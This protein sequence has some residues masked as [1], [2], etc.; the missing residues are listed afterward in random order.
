MLD[1]EQ[2]KAIVDRDGSDSIKSQA[3]L[4]R[5]YY[6]G[7]HDIMDY[8]I[9]FY[10]AHGELAEDKGRSNLRISHPYFTELC[11]QQV[12]YMLSD[13]EGYISA[14]ENKELQER[15][16]DYFDEDFMGSM[17]D[18]LTD[19]VSLGFGYLYCYK[20]VEDRLVFE[21]AD[22]MGVVEVPEKESPDGEAHIIYSYFDRND[23]KGA[24]IVKIQVWDDR[25]TYYWVRNANGEIVYDEEVEFNP[26]PHVMYKSPDGNAFG[27]ALG[28]IP[29]F[30]LDNNRKRQSNLA[31]IKNLIDDY[32]LV[33]CGLS[34]NIQDYDN[35][36]YAV[37]GFQG[38]NLDE[39]MASL[40]TKRMVGLDADG[41]IELKTVDIPYEARR[42]KLE[43]DERNIYHF[44]MG[45]NSNMVG[46]GNVTNVVIKSRYALLDMK[47]NKLEVRLKKFL[48]DILDI[49]LN[50]INGQNGTKYTQKQ[51]KIKFSREIMTNALD[52]AQIE[53][54]NAESREIDINTLL[55]LRSLI[56]DEQ[57]L[58]LICEN[59]DLDFEEL[60]KFI[61]EDPMANLGAATT[62][63]MGGGVGGAQ[64]GQ[65]DPPAEP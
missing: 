22:A 53:K 65:G 28:F 4:G 40:K 25:Q 26:R 32:D 15:L 10:D 59:L 37:T 1:A 8:R 13:P 29:F 64:G 58:K 3:K 7:R 2:I 9:F 56:G 57:T 34:N 35:P 11:D 12:Q 62:M 60:K 30:R 61:P 24:A 51:V 46:D 54:Y 63:L 19:V 23:D 47:C 42:T 31:V 49:V 36:I 16:D 33:N 14:G 52:N 6:E 41:S 38:N 20:G 39:L 21:A 55:N 44:G 43:M 17:H 48:R 45:L 50:D 5:R 18:F 27:E